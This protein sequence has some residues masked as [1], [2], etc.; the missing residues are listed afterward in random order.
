MLPTVPK[1]LNVSAPTHRNQR[2][3]IWLHQQD[4]A[5][6]W[7]RWDGIV[8][9]LTDY[10]TWVNRQSKLVGLV[11]IDV[12]GKE[13]VDDFMTHLYEISQRIPMILLPQSILALKSQ[14]FWSDNFDN[15]LNLNTV[16]EQYPFLK[17][18][19]DG[20]QEDAIAIFAIICRYHCLVDCVETRSSAIE[21]PLLALSKQTP[22][23]AWLFLQY[24]IP[25]SKKRLLEIKECLKRNC[26]SPYVDRIVLLNEKDYSGEWATFPGA[27]KIQQVVIKTRLTYADVLRYVNN[28]VPLGVYV[29]L[30]NADIYMGKSV[31]DLWKINMEDRLL[32][33][34]RWDDFGTGPDKAAIFGPRADSQ[35]TWIF[36]SDSVK[37][38]M[39]DYKSFQFQLGQAGCDN[40]FAGWMLRQR[41]LLS[42]PALSFQTFHLHNS[43][44]RT[45]KQADAIKADIYLNIAPTYLIDTK[46][47][48]V[49]TSPIEHLCNESVEFM[50]KSSSM[51][52]EITYCTM[53]EK[54]G[55][56]VWEPSVENYY[57]EPAI[58]VYTWNTGAGVTANGLVYDLSTVYTG[59]HV[60]DPRFNYWKNATVDIFTPLQ[61][62]LGTMLAIPF[63]NTTVYEDPDM[64]VTY[65]LSRVIRLLNLYPDAHYWLPPAFVP[66][67]EGISW[68]TRQGIVWNKDTACWANKVAG[69]LPGPSCSE[70]GREDITGLRTILKWKSYPTGLVCSV[71]VDDVLTEDLAYTRILPFLLLHCRGWT[72][73][74]VRTYQDLQGSTMC[75]M[76]NPAHRTDTAKIWALPKKAC[77][78]EFQQELALHGEC[79]HVAHVADLKSWVLLLSKGPVKDVQEQI[80][81][82]VDKWLKKNMDE[83]V[84]R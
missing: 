8:A 27:E 72:M 49:P 57:F 48:K 1:Q 65:Y 31:L 69:F 61:T 75:I 71:F 36:L 43:G 16:H 47:E 30:C 62:C 80:V 5:V 46:Q 81:K 23:E 83:V 6:N 7:S 42:N 44:V 21:Y 25:S 38:R 53:L 74:T 54:E 12:P 70:L 9:S 32:A 77:V 2:T 64:Y 63:E 73:R 52:N 35:D 39:W 28:H 20:S 18:E 34:L 13:E 15:L 50:V 22:P 29:M 55:R 76:H 17:K 59:K 11:H 84:L 45:Y 14:V 4:P 51:S 68:N 40:A 58:P 56:Y 60:E 41:F 19:W 37:H 67:L 66:F 78:L 79:Q 10:D 82:Q 33:L 24:Y 3:L 26:A